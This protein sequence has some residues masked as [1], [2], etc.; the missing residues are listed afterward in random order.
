MEPIIATVV[1]AAVPALLPAAM[2]DSEKTSDTTWEK[3]T[4]L[5]LIIGVILFVVNQLGK[6]T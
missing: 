2:K 3:W 6:N 1:S 5:L 4:K